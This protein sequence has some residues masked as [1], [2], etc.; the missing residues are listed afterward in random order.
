MDSF[1]PMQK[2]SVTATNRL[3][4]ISSL[5]HNYMSVFNGGCDDENRMQ[6]E[7]AAANTG[8]DDV[9]S[10]GVARKQPAVN[11]SWSGCHHAKH[12]AMW[13]VL[14]IGRLFGGTRTLAAQC[15]LYGVVVLIPIYVVS[16]VYFGTYRYQYAWT[17][18]SSFISGWT[19]TGLIG[20]A[21]VI[22]MCIFVVQF[23]SLLSPI[24]HGRG[25]GSLGNKITISDQLKHTETMEDS[26]VASWRISLSWAAIILLNAV[27]VILANVGFVIVTIYHGT[28]YYML[29]T[30]WALALFKFLWNNKALRWV[31]YAIL[32]RA[33]DVKQPHNAR[34]IVSVELVAALFNNIFV[35]CLVVAIIDRSCF[36]NFLVAAPAVKAKYTYVECVLPEG[37]G[38]F[39]RTC[40]PGILGRQAEIGR[41]TPANIEAFPSLNGRRKSIGAGQYV[42]ESTQQFGPTALETGVAPR[43]W[44]RSC[45]R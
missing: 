36:Y 4:E 24:S 17:V 27:V 28:T 44:P 23:H 11:N 43:G 41:T 20:A 1:L 30:Q 10:G 6:T 40:E 31:V 3:N 15:L 12:E 37:S 5:F 33:E 22:F 16:S 18:S 14:L 45:R 38:D 35:P 9:C 39:G 25:S 19:A 29:A 8:G 26:A 7:H 34:A 42:D 21:L 13:N 32:S 2:A